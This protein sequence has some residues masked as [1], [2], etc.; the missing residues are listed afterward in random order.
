MKSKKHLH[1][2]SGI[3]DKSVPNEL[4]MHNL[5]FAATFKTEIDQHLHRIP[6]K[7]SKLSRTTQ[8][9]IASVNYVNQ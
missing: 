1:V 5:H 2:D 3:F 6:P 8:M 4:H 9:S 7:K